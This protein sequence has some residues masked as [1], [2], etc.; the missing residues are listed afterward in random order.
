[1]QSRA[2]ETIPGSV[3]GT[4][5]L[6][7]FSKSLLLGHLSVD[8]TSEPSG[9]R[10]EVSCSYD[11]ASILRLLPGQENEEFAEYDE[12]VP[13]DRAIIS[14]GQCYCGRISRHGLVFLISQ[15]LQDVTTAE[16]TSGGSSI[17][18][19]TTLGRFTFYEQNDKSFVH[20]DRSTR[21]PASIVDLIPNQNLDHILKAA[22]G[23][24]YLFDA[25]AAKAAEKSGDDTKFFWYKFPGNPEDLATELRFGMPDAVI[26]M[27]GDVLER[28]NRL[29]RF[30]KAMVNAM[31]NVLDD[32][33][34]PIGFVEVLNKLPNR[35]RS[36]ANHDGRVDAGEG[37]D[38]NGGRAQRLAYTVYHCESYANKKLENVTLEGGL[39]EISFVCF[40]SNFEIHLEH[41][42]FIEES[43]I[44]LIH[45]HQHF[46]GSQPN[47]WQS[48]IIPKS[49]DCFKQLFRQYL[50]ACNTSNTRRCGDTLREELRVL[51][52]FN[53]NDIV[54]V[55]FQG[56]YAALALLNC[57]K[58][59]SRAREA[60][61]EW[62][63]FIV[64]DDDY[65]Y[66]G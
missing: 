43:L 26:Y 37:L 15:H 54:L 21:S 27:N 51:L 22:S 2:L 4:I 12:D 34:V 53:S 14:R 29:K 49:K 63:R 9:E 18:V 13:V 55:I 24:R 60:P 1:M 6:P 42:K 61:E 58:I 56:F 39:S 64:A 31:T 66:I 40:L 52:N 50:V 59:L 25:K 28:W 20:F 35:C 8:T 36:S 3:K 32:L 38:A 62:N 10:L 47:H 65:I 46:N 48:K 11:L 41:L 45:G 5:R 30:S 44:N 57:A 33:E 7:R 16:T 17:V 23:L 19:Q